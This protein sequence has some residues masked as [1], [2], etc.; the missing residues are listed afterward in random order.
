MSERPV[1]GLVSLCVPVYNGA[2]YLPETLASLR[3]QDHADLE[4]I[5]SDNG[6]SDATEEICRAA[7]AD[8]ERIKYVRSPVNRGGAWNFNAALGLARGEYSKIAAADDV[9]LPRFVSGCVAA[10][11]AG[12]PEY[13]L[14]FPRTRLIDAHST[15]FEDLQDATLHVDQD[16]ASERIERFLRAQASHIVYGLMR[17]DCVRAT[18][19]FRPVVGDDLVLLV[20]LACRGRFAL[21]DEQL[22]LQR[23]HD[24]QF[25]ARGVDQTDWYAPGRDARFTFPQTVS[26]WELY[27][28]VRTSPVPMAE[29]ARC[30]SAITGTW[31]LPRWRAMVGDVARASGLPPQLWRR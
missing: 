26:N 10:L 15:V 28:A 12:G 5:I 13:I 6:S 21:V 1:R 11:E 25:S 2:R 22:F 29:K 14:A 30:V 8:D 3:A 24:A 7:V 31:V 19:G 27:R 9:L 20:E 4:V 17:T 18:R 23:R 16:T